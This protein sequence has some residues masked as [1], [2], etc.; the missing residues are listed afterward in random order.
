MRVRLAMIAVL[1][2][3]VLAAAC[4]GPRA[5]RTGEVESVSVNWAP[6]TDLY[7]E[8]RETT[9]PELVAPLLEVLGTLGTTVTPK[10]LEGLPLHF[11]LHQKGG[12]ERRFELWTPFLVDADRKVVYF[13]SAEQ[14]AALDTALEP[15]L[16][17]VPGAPARLSGM[18]TVADLVAALRERGA[19]DAEDTGEE[20]RFLMFG[21]RSGRV[22][23]VLGET[24]QVYTLESPKAAQKAAAV[25]PYDMPVEWVAPPRFVAVGNL[26]VTVVVPDQALSQKIALYL[27]MVR[28]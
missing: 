24:V 12:G 2:V 27:E 8:P 4:S 9:E 6:G 20:I 16:P 26:V 23:R 22:I 1:G 11:A 13:L 14:Q 7:T 28:Q 15:L 3:A 17:P 5:V 25:D 18:I 21:A 10:D 19:G